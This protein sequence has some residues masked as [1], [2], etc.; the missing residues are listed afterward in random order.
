MKKLLILLTF[1][2]FSSIAFAQSIP[3]QLTQNSDGSWQLLRNGEPYLIQGAGGGG[4]LELLAQYGGNTIRTWGIGEDT[5]D[6]LDEAHS[7]G[8]AVILGHWLGHE[9]HGFDYDDEEMLKDQ[10]EQVRRDVLQFKDHPAVLMWTLGNEMEGFDDGSNPK[11]WN[12]VQELASMVKELDPN[13]PIMTITAEIGGA[14]VQAVHEIT[15]HIDIHGVNTYGGL[16]SMIDRYKAAGGTKPI[17]ITEFGPPGTWETGTTSFGAPIEL[18]STQKAS[19]Y[20]EAYQQG[21]LDYPGL[22]LGGL[23]FTWGS[24]MEATATW[25][26]MFLPSGEKLAAVDAMAQIWSGSPPNNLS[27]VIERF[28][29]QGPNQLVA[30]DLFDIQLNAYDPEGK[31]LRVDWIVRGEATEYFTGG[32][33]QQTPFE[34]DGIIIESNN[35][36]ATL[37][38][39]T[40]GVYR[41]YAK[42]FDPDGAAAVANIPVKTTGKTNPVQLA[43]PLAVYADD[44]PQPW[45][46]SGWMGNTEKIEMN[47]N[48]TTE[49]HSGKHSLEVKYLG[50]DGW[51]GVAWQHPLNDWGQLPGGFNLNGAEKLTFWARGKK[52]GEKVSFGIGIL[53]DDVPYNDTVMKELSEVKLSK[54]WKQYSINLRGEDLS[55]IKTPFWWRLASPGLPVTFYLDNIQFE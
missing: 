41:I 31:E 24:K 26:G 3:V 28:E 47:L 30:G 18:T 29:L 37:K 8:L 1:F 11:I 17:I 46:N 45:F 27:P 6:L 40:E 34:L 4:S 14:R 51:A 48:S 20:R 42:I 9:R 52:G 44:A 21:C 16:P 22:C 2:A 25:F 39:P 54:E 50:F 13:H 12:H 19:V 55:Q 32:D 38:A 15:T 35:E 49:S 43:L 36:S 33:A 5:A 53:A 23:A 7:Y 10:R